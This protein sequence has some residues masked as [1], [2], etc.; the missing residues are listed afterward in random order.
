MKIIM[1]LRLICIFIAI[2]NSYVHANESKR[3]DIEAG[4]SVVIPAPSIK[5]IAVGNGN[6]VQANAMNGKEVLVFGKSK[7]TTTMDLWFANG[8]RVSYQ[9]I[10]RPDG[11][12]RIHEELTQLLKTIPNA[13]ALIA[14]DKVVIQGEDLS[15]SDRLKISNI[16]K[17]YPDVIDFSSQQGWDRM[18]L[19]DV[20]VIEIPTTRMQDLGVRWDPSTDGGMQTGIAWEASTP[21][22]LQ[23]AGQ[24][25]LDV[26]YPANHIAGMF[27][28]NAL[29]NARIAALSKSGEAV[30][31]AQPQLLTRSGSTASFLAGG[32]V[33]Y[34]AVD[35]EGRSITTFRKYGVS[36]NITPRA[37]RLGAIRSK[38]EI[39]VSSVDAT[40]SVPGGPALKVRRASTEFNVRSG[41]TL[42]VGGFLSRERTIDREGI[43]GISD[44]PVLGRLFSAER[45]QSRQ[46]ELA[47]FVTPIVVDADDPQMVL[48][49]SKGNAILSDTFKQSPR[50]IDRYR[51][52]QTVDSRNHFSGVHSQWEDMPL[53]DTAQQ[54]E[55]DLIHSSVNQWEQ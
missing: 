5:R 24:A 13:Q 15:D 16:S 1:C 51:P 7:G 2:P 11:I 36:L 40:I 41:Q 26:A 42:V 14:G 17:I 21:N 55:S 44:V 39:E 53:E 37:D 19:L 29:L 35:K 34:A 6:I 49:A 30:V 43:P 28:L 22:I 3:L 18:V 32:E 20:Q 12:K 23:R 33:P 45:E 54:T 10:V 50:L 38:L 25:A 46:T 52:D 27:G 47:I 31:L 48:R 4:S 8:K 9:I